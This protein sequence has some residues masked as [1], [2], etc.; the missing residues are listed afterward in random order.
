LVAGPLFIG[1]GQ[2]GSLS[3]VCR[4]LRPHLKDE[5]VI[6]LTDVI[7]AL[8]FVYLGVALVRPEWF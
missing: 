1:R 6:Y 3:S 4:R 7:V 2:H 5:K 8:L